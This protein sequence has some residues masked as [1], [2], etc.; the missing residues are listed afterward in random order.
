MA[1]DIAPLPADPSQNKATIL[2]CE[3]G[4]PID[5]SITG[6]ICESCLRTRIDVTAGIQ[7]EAQ[8]HTCRDCDR[9]M[10]PPSQWITAAPESRELLALCLRKLRGLNRVRIIDANFVYRGV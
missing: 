5:G 2:C 9:W 10:S 1:T 8:L 6:A 4:I 3:C 7:R